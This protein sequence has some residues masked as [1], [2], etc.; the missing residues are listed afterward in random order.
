MKKWYMQ[1]IVVI[2]HCKIKAGHSK[3]V[4]L[5]CLFLIPAVSKSRVGYWVKEEIRTLERSLSYS[6]SATRPPRLQT[7]PSFDL[8][9][10]VGVKEKTSE[11]DTA[12]CTHGYRSSGVGDVAV[13]AVTGEEAAADRV[14]AR[15]RSTCGSC[16]PS[17]GPEGYDGA[18]ARGWQ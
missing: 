1:G 17:A 18:V 10:C 13:A 16:R 8:K 2:S 9:T 11:A 14:H 6:R 12:V 15:S 3:T 5:L 4:E 7:R